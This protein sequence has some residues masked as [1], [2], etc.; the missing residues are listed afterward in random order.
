MAKPKI[1]WDMDSWGIYDNWDKTSK[2]LPGI[3]EF[4][5]IVPARIGVEFGYILNI[6]KAKGKKLYYCIEHPPFLDDDGNVSP[7]FDGELYVKSNDWDFY[8]GD[9][10]WE[11]AHDKIGTWRM[12]VKVDGILLADKSFSV[13]PDHGEAD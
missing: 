7:P 4:T 3:V 5:E 8:L 10:I 1:S 9:S 2:D 11:P 12:I 6:K 13:V